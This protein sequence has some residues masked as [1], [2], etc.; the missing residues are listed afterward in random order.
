M[1]Y[2]TEV[3]ILMKSALPSYVTFASHANDIFRLQPFENLSRSFHEYVRIP[4]WFVLPT[5]R[6]AYVMFLPRSDMCCV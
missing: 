2:V 4:L 1:R 3:T 5:S 6:L